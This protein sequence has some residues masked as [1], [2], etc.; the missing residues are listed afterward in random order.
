MD[1]KYEDIQE[2]I[3]CLIEARV[4]LIW[5]T[6][7]EEDRFIRELKEVT[8]DPMGKEVYV[9]SYYKGL[10][11]YNAYDEVGK[12]TEGPFMETWEP[13]KALALIEKQVANRKETKDG[14]IIENSG[15][16][17]MKDLHPYLNAIICRQLR[18]MCDNLSRSLQT[19]IIISPTLS[20]LQ[21][22]SG[23]PI[24]LE[25]QVTVIN[26]KLPTLTQ[27]TEMINKLLEDIKETEKGTTTID[28]RS[29]TPED[30]EIFGRSLQGLTIAEA[31]TAIITSLLHLKK[32]VPEMLIQEK[33]RIISKND[34][35]EFIECVP[36]IK[37]VGGLEKAKKY[38]SMYRK[39]HSSKAK[40][41]GVEPLRGV[42]MTG[43]PGTGKSLLSKAVASE[44]FSPILRLDIGKVMDSLVG[45]SEARMR[46]VVQ[47]AESMAPVIL[48][49]DE[50][51][52]ALSG[53]KSSNHS[54]GGTMA[55]VFGTLLQAMQE[56]LDGVTI[57][58]TA[59]DVSALP[60]EFIR[61]FNEV[62]FVDLPGEEARKEIIKIH[63][64]KRKRDPTHFNIDEIATAAWS[65]TGAEI[66][67]AI[68]DAIASAFI[69]EK[70]LDTEEILISLQQTRP[71]STVM[72]ESIES[73]RAWARDRARYASE[74]SLEPKKPL[75][76]NKP[77]EESFMN[78]YNVR[79]KNRK[80][81]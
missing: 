57:L 77:L 32:I 65:Y 5:V 2:E 75:V 24:L 70:E 43:I 69:K 63:L 46:Q 13:N 37:E 16:Y 52:K 27:L 40:E 74:E 19:I 59:N 58:A 3:A 8:A 51:E 61:R 50:V 26:Y 38:F 23:L 67:K 22:I 76:T 73:L 49:V 71:I 54:D 12:E 36:Q 30:I 14:I 34:I 45:S 79:G 15:I 62:F 25:K 41:F 60:P 21:D 68:K 17:I 81:N 6:T 44:W 10:K 39:A 28:L 4:P 42:L 20:H 7:F 33:K 9:W 47:Q 18:D 53:T 80:E 72:K 11:A 48:W 1:V 35:L 78:L 66:E 56:G 64:E 55:R 29:Y 31:R